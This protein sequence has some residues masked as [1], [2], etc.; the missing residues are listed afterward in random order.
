VRIGILSSKAVS[1]SRV[2]DHIATVAEENGL[3]PVRLPRTYNAY[4]IAELAD[5][6]IIVM[7]PAP[8]I[9]SPLM[10]LYRDLAVNV[11]KPVVWY[12]MIEGKIPLHSVRDWMRRDLTV[13]P[14]SRYTKQKLVEAG[15]R[16]TDP[17]PHGVMPEEVEKAVAMG[18]RR[19]SE[20]RQKFGD[21]KILYTVSHSH[22]RKYLNGYAEALR[23]LAERRD[24]YVA[25][26]LTDQR[27]ADLLA[28]VPN[29]YVDPNYEK[30]THVAVMATMAASDLVV[31]PSASEGFGL[32]PLEANA[33]GTLAVH[34]ELPVLM[35][36]SDPG[37]NFVV[38]VVDVEDFPTQDGIVYELHLYDPSDMASALSDALDMLEK[39]PSEIEERKRRARSVLITHNVHVLY[40][41]LIGVV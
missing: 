23:K 19:R 9:A 21:K 5:R 26:I 16:A 30:P 11:R 29:T 41:Q 4:D 31:L 14:C 37:A 39:N 6:F 15:I 34:A 36:Y 24:D 18:E 28:G 8:T 7:P 12:G 1:L 20:L 33:V 3:E 2:A 13:T 32:I 35:E 38:P 22:P 10:L 25:Y 17:V 40:K 27:G